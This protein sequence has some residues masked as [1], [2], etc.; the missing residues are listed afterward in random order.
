MEEKPEIYAGM[1]GCIC[2]HL[3]VLYIRPIFISHTGSGYFP[4]MILLLPHIVI[5]SVL[6]A[7]HPS[8][9]TGSAE[10]LSQ[11]AVQAPPP[12]QPGEGSVD[13]LANLQAIQ[14]LMGAV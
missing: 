6:L 1:D 13:W 14:N 8:I 10:N 7:T 11:K 3:Y 4:R 5:L 9:R 12:S 2:F